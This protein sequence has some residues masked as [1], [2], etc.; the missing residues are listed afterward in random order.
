MKNFNS[1]DLA[2]TLSIG[3]LL[4]YAFGFVYIW[5]FVDRHVSVG[6]VWLT[7]SA[8]LETLQIPFSNGGR[9]DPQFFDEDRSQD[10]HHRGAK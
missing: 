10:Q 8:D 3:L 2:R 4:C 1:D 6:H 7:S 5:N 9:L